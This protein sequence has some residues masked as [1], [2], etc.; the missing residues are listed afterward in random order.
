MA[1]YHCAVKIL[2]RSAGRSSVQFSAYMSGE[3]MKDERLNVTFNHTSKEEVCHNLMIYA[4]RVPEEIRTQEKFWNSLEAAEKNNNSQVARTWEIALPHELTMEQNK[5]WAERYARSLVYKDGMPAVQI[6]IHEKDGNWHA[7]IMAPTR[8]M[9]EKG[10]WL[11]KETKKYSLDENGERIPVLDQ[12][13]GKQK[14]E[15]KTGRKVWQR[16]TVERNNWNSPELLMEWRE[17]A[18]RYQNRA[19]EKEHIGE[20]VD[21]R[22]FEEQGIDREP[23]IHEGYTA[24]ILT[25]KGLFSERVEY[26]RGVRLRN[27][28]RAEYEAERTHAEQAEKLLEHFKEKIS[29]VREQIRASLDRIGERIRERAVHEALV[30]NRGGVR[31]TTGE[32]LRSLETEERTSEKIRENKVNERENREL[33]RDRLRSAELERQARRVRHKSHDI[34]I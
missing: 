24:R 9:S 21:H 1:C 25:E 30:S 13:T 5:E 3:K 16:E 32:F 2:S 22:S 26:N 17:R 7:H 18:A 4:D 34:T 28:I 27:E 23:T 12:R 20:R 19:L 33:E 8:D 31:K 11:S 14:I 6:S 15:A 10:R 29:H